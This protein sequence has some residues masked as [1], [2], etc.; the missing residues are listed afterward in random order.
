MAE[1][2]NDIGDDVVVDSAKRLPVRRLSLYEAVTQR[3]REMVL[4]GE[5]AP[6]SRISEKQ[7]CEIF[8][9]SRTPLR[10]ALKV[11]A[12]EGLVELLPNR[13]AKVTEVTLR[14]V[15][16]LFEVMVVLEGLSGELL[17]ARAS[18]ADIAEIRA[19]HQRMIELYQRH[20]RAEYFLLNQDIH[21][22]LTEIA[23]NSVLLELETS[24]SV[25]ITRARY[26]ANMLMGRWDESASEH[27]LIIEALEKRDAQELST[28]MRMHMRKTGDAVIQRLQQS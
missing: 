20:E 27:E 9:V 3:L 28:A 19:M 16:D 14:E 22:R 26:M 21:R 10:E 7:L 15:V 6:G 1:I 12:N 18:N 23:G 24:L 13:G 11:L 2:S 25:K 4:E 8:D 17:V 5:L